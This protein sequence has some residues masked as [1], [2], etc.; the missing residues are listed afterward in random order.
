M[1][2]K[3]NIW[4]IKRNFVESLGIDFVLYLNILIIAHDNVVV[5][6][7][8]SMDIKEESCVVPESFFNNWGK[9]SSST[10][11]QQPMFKK[12]EGSSLTSGQLKL[13][14]ALIPV[15]RPKPQGQLKVFVPCSENSFYST[16]ISRER[17]GS[18][19]DDLSK[20]G[21]KFSISDKRTYGLEWIVL[22]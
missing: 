2:Y 18:L 19:A 4:K 5:V 9:K 21:I 11:E 14:A 6:I 8:C 16:I 1:L 22:D 20:Y 15:V 3:H 13:L 10:G 17:L 12:A 7:L